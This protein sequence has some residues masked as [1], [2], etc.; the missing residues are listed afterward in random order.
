M[1]PHTWR[2]SPQRHRACRFITRCACVVNYTTIFIS[3]CLA[4]A[5]HASGLQVLR[6]RSS[7]I[8]GPFAARERQRTVRRTTST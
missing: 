7:V 4:C 1:L 8:T 6:P 3:D 2:D 5:A